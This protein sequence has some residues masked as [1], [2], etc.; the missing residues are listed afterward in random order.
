MDIMEVI[1]GNRPEFVATICHVMLESN[2]K[3]EVLHIINSKLK[4][5]DSED[6][7]HL[8]LIRGIVYYQTGSKEKALDDI[9]VAFFSEPDTDTTELQEWF[10]EFYPEVVEDPE[11]KALPLLREL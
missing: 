4:T 2:L 11:V 6:Y 8:M 3:K 10:S 7:K 5:A 1:S 9:L